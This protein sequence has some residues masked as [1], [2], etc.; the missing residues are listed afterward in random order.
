MSDD[1]YVELNRISR[2]HHKIVAEAIDN[3]NYD[4]NKQATKATDKQ[5]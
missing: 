4:N 5:I 1:T 2:S 3:N